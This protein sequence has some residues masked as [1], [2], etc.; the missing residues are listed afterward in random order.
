VAASDLDAAEMPLGASEWQVNL[1]VEHPLC[2][3][4]LHFVEGVV[5]LYVQAQAQAQAQSTGVARNSKDVPIFLAWDG[6][7]SVDDYRSRAKP[8]VIAADEGRLKSM[9]EDRVKLVDMLVSMNAELFVLNPR[10]TF[11]WQIYLVRVI[12]GLPSVPSMQHKD[13]FCEQQSAYDARR[14]KQGKEA[15]AGAP[16]YNGQWV[17]WAS[18]KAA[19][20]EHG[21]DHRRLSAQY[22]TP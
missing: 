22:Q 14:V 18:V 8:A 3:Y 12:L 10:S 2:N 7:G 15:G 4:P 16:P 1:S 6:R 19:R 9:P 17:S 21:V 5:E 13:V 11:S 20:E